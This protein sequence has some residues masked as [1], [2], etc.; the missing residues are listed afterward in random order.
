MPCDLLR[1]MKCKPNGMSH[2][3]AETRPSFLLLQPRNPET[4]PLLPESRMGTH[5]TQPLGV[6]EPS[7]TCRWSGQSDQPPPVSDGRTDSGLVTCSL[8][9]QDR[10]LSRGLN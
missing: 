1:P 2:F 8:E 7:Q 4:G 6:S 10:P 3:W 9:M 5:G